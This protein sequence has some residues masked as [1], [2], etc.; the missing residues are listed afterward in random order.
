MEIP[1]CKNYEKIQ[2]K[3]ERKNIMNTPFYET[4]YGRKF[5]D[6]QLPELIKSLNR[7]ADAQ[8][9]ANGNNAPAAKTNVS[10]T[11]VGNSTMFLVHE[12]NYDMPGEDAVDE[13]RIAIFRTKKEAVN[14]AEKRRAMYLKLNTYLTQDPLFNSFADSNKCTIFYCYNENEKRANIKHFEIRITELPIS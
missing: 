8:E 13:S 5:F 14:N 2:Y 10:D 9:A 4:G 11:C 6:V 1:K 12:V 3:L 7:V